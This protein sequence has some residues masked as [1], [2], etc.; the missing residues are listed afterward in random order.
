MTQ[1]SSGADKSIIEYEVICA[2]QT[3]HTGFLFCFVLFVCVLFVC[4]LLFFHFQF[5][6]T[7]DFF[8]PTFCMLEFLFSFSVSG[9]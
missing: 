5:F 4:L 2:H 9:S 1:S 8:T 7:F 3:V 6:A